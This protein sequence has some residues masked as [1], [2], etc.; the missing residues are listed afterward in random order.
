MNNPVLVEVTRGGIVESSHH[1]SYAVCNGDGELVAQAGDVSAPVFPRSAIKAFQ[2]LA[3]VEAGVADAFGFSEAEIA[4]AC[5]S[6]NG[7]PA[8]VETAR[9]MLSKAGVAEGA[10]ECGPHWPTREEAGRDLASAGGEPGAVHN[11]C[12]G[13]HSGMLALAK[14]LGAD[15]KGYT[16]PEHP[17]QQRIAA[18]LSELCNADVTAAPCGID[19]CSVPTWALP[20]QSWALGF[21]RFASG[22][23]LSA[24]RQAAAN[25]I[26]A[27][28]KANP[29]MVAGT[30]RFCTEVME[31]VPRVFIKTGAEGVF[32]GAI[33]HNGTGIALK[34]DDGASRAAE[35]LMARLLID[36]GGLD[37][38]E[39]KVLEGFAATP[40]VNRAN[41]KTGVLRAVKNRTN[42]P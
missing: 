7:E 3:M 33:P 42:R 29:F 27:A 15:L 1:G 8:H 37:E 4:L 40:V 36:F 34:C 20:L 23:G 6:H 24:E 25:R 39:C 17:V 18:F 26:I 22:K 28:V 38:G 35:K 12:S 31:A 5:S 21:S 30:G 41:I 13:K 9:S 16:W 2:A 10:Y 19:G 14:H 32:C 11:N